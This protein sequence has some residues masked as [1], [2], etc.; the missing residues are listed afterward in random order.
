MQPHLHKSSSEV[1]VFAP[2]ALNP[3]SPQQ[4]STLRQRLFSLG[5]SKARLNYTLTEITAAQ[6][7]LRENKEALVREISDYVDE[8]LQSLEQLRQVLASQVDAAFESAR[9]QVLQTDVQGNDL[10]TLLWTCSQTQQFSCLGVFSATLSKLT[11][12]SPQD[13]VGV[14]WSSLLLPSGQVNYS[15]LLPIRPELDQL[16]AVLCE[17]GVPL[18]SA[19]P[20]LLRLNALF[21][22]DT[23]QVPLMLAMSHLFCYFRDAVPKNI[24]PALE[25]VSRCS[26]SPENLANCE[27]L[28]YLLTQEQRFSAVDLEVIASDLTSYTPPPELVEI[29]P[30]HVRIFDCLSRQWRSKVAL[31]SSLPVDSLSVLTFL[32]SGKVFVCGG[33]NSASTYQLDAKKGFILQLNDMKTPRKAHG[34]QLYYGRIYVF[35]GKRADDAIDKCE[36]YSIYH[37]SWT[38]LGNSM[39]KPRSHFSPCLHRHLIYLCGGNSYSSE[40][41]NPETEAFTALSGNL[42]DDSGCRT[43]VWNEQLVVISYK[44]LSIRPLTGAKFAPKKKEKFRCSGQTCATILLDSRLWFTCWNPAGTIFCFDLQSATLETTISYD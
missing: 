43:V 36:K 42:P 40:V 35:G 31:A 17:R 37:G 30:D 28:E 22:S 3:S 20:Q 32:P 38:A 41:F 44:F 26:F 11:A 18:C 8:Q 27:S 34:L 15:S 9:L 16:Q 12:L 19:S 25:A 13:L 29:R 7:A 21:D 24:S 33:E 23:L 2:I 1:H 4:L 39:L 5:E 14:S 10:T 6:T